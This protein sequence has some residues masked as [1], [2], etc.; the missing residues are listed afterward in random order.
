MAYLPKNKLIYTVAVF[1]ERGS[2]AL[3][4]RV[5]CSFVSMRDAIDCLNKEAEYYESKGYYPGE[6]GWD[7]MQATKYVWQGLRGNDFVMIIASINPIVQ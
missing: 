3:D 5:S 6:N 7:D 1:E 4:F 2:G